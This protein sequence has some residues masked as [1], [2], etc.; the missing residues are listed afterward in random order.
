M[1]IAIGKGEG[2]KV[3]AEFAETIAPKLVLQPCQLDHSK[4]KT[5]CGISPVLAGDSLEICPCVL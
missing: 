2:Q 3:M 4:Y 1:Q 5:R